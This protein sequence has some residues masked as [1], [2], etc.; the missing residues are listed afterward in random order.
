MKITDII[1]ALN[2][3]SK[4]IS[5]YMNNSYFTGFEMLGFH[6]ITCTS[7]L[8]DYWYY[9]EADKLRNEPF[10]KDHQWFQC[11]LFMELTFCCFCALQR[12]NIL[13]GKNTLE[14]DYLSLNS[15]STTCE[16][17]GQEQITNISVSRV[18]KYKMQMFL[19][20]T[21]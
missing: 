14:Q 18:L 10:A 6:K 12:N 9:M 7:Y 20:L 16:L 5:I 11:R 4:K 13:F 3:W 8:N 17:C 19:A 15:G 1:S 21:S 2:L